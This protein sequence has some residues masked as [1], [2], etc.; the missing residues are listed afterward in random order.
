M[1]INFKSLQ[2]INLFLSQ[3]NKN[4]DLLIVSKN[5]SID[6]IEILLSQGYNKFG[7]NRVQEA[8]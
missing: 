6:D 4:A 2:S 1:S 3:E 7:E 5:Q 8:I